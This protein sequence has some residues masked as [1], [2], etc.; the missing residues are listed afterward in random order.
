MPELPEVEVTRRRIEGLL[1]GRRISRVLTTRNSYFFLTDP[2]RLRRGLVGREVTGLERH[3]KYLVAGLDD[4][5]RLLRHL[6]MSGQLFAEEA[7]SPRLLSASARSSLTPEQQSRFAP[8]RHTHLQLCFEDGGSRVL[9]RDVR[10]F[11]KVRLL[12]P[13][14]REPRLEKLGVDA[15]VATGEQLFRAT[16][17]RKIEIKSLLLDQSSI[18]GVGNIYAD[19]CLFLARVRPTRRSRRMTRR[20]CNAVIEALHGI[21]QRAIEAGGSS[22]SD[23]IA[24]DGTDGSYQNERR[25][26]ARTGEPCPE[27]GSKLR[28]IT[29]AQRGTHFCAKC[30]R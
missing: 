18:A 12:D 2:R 26:Y 20:E 7:V 30:Q 29:I 9:M 25:V 17:G 16:R 5:R 11:G 14:E 21:L 24:P 15:L 8:D 6:G 27:C 23:Y 19:E 1:V 22:I 10:K 28:R 3:G 13:G 4:D